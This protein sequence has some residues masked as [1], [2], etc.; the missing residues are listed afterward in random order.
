MC[1]K[2]LPGG[3]CERHQNEL[4]LREHEEAEA[5][6]RQIVVAESGHYVQVDQPQTV[7]DA[8]REVVEI[9]RGGSRP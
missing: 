7:I 2:Q 6:G 8:V 1:A 9:V 3:D 4:L 5:R